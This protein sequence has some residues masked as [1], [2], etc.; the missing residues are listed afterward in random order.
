MGMYVNPKNYGMQI[1]KLERKND[2]LQ[3][4][5]PY[6]IAN[7]PD[8]ETHLNQYNVL[9][10]DVATYFYGAKK[11]G[12]VLSAMDA[13]LLR[14]MIEEFPFLKDLEP[15]NTPDAIAKVFQKDGHP[16]VVIIDEYD[17][18]IRD[19]PDER[20]LILDYLQYLRG[21]FKTGE[22]TQ[23]LALGYLT[24]ILPIKKIQGESALNNFAEYTMTN[25]KELVTY[26]GFTQKE[27]E[28]LCQKYHVRWRFLLR[29]Q[30]YYLEFC[31]T[32]GRHHR[33]ACRRTPQR[34]C[35]WIP[36]RS[37][38]FPFKR[39][40]ICLPDPYGISGVR[41]LYQADIYAKYGD[42]RGL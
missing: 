32:Q 15:L 22:S 8:F 42:S 11:P 27:V 38:A 35:T 14:D 3:S 30:L 21:F 25:P 37:D 20:K 16:F 31:R 29:Q 2:T 36:K 7:D 5:A 18:I 17:C 12:D 24:G 33:L 19:A 26:F 13:A 9:H 34:G 6:E 40:R 28:T 41:C 1:A 39:R 23:F 10:F 4:A